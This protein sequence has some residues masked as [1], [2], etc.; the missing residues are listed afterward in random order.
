MEGV[1]HSCSLRDHDARLAA[2]RLAFAV[3]VAR[4]GQFCLV[5]QHGRIGPYQQM[6]RLTAVVAAF[7]V[8]VLALVHVFEHETEVVVVKAVHQANA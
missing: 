4:E 1:F 7:H 6:Y 5:I 3:N 2:E 8:K